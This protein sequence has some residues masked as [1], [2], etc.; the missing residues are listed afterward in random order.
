ML[1]IEQKYVLSLI[2]NK[3]EL[4][5]EELKVMDK[6]KVI[7]ILIEHKIFVHYIEKIKKDQY[8]TE[9]YEII[10]GIYQKQIQKQKTR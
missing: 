4:T 6:M 2:T 7:D 5:I 9:Y 10:E 8:F 3:N 1:N